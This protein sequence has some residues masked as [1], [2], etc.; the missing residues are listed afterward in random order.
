MIFSIQ[1]KVITRIKNRHVFSDV[2]D[3]GSYDRHF[4]GDGEGD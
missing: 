3:G 1:Y 4:S 2:A